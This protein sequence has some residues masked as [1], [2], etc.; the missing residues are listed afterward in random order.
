MPE[1]LACTLLLFE[2]DPSIRTMLTAFF[3]GQGAKVEAAADGTGAL[4]RIRAVQPDILLLDVIMPVQDGLSIL[5]SIRAIDPD[6]PVI[7]LTEKDGVDD[8]VTGLEYG[9]DDYMTK[10]FSPKELLARVRAQLRRSRRVPPTADSCL[11]IGALCLDPAAREV[12]LAGGG[13]LPLT[14]TEFDLMAYLAARPGAV[15]SHA[16]LL[17]EVLG[18]DP[19]VETKAMVMHIANIRR[20]ID[21]YCPLA[22]TIKAVSGVGYKLIP[23]EA[24]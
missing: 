5:Q 10:P 17:R 22:L 9:A 16:E 11:Q 21:R 20:K 12:R 14:K 2:D 15:V 4:E 6:L 1:P 8:K 23:G 7:M 24:K 3:S 13:L 19:E 18:Y